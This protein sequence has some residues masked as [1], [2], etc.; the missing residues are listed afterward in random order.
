LAYHGN[1]H[2][3]SDQSLGGDFTHRTREGNR[4]IL[5]SAGENY[6]LLTP[7]PVI[8]KSKSGMEITFATRGDPGEIT[9]GITLDF[10]LGYDKI[11]N[12]QLL[13]P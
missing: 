12:S 9:P 2:G 10:L 6:Y 5:S 13:P 3:A 7:S 4:V 8:R 1:T 11:Q